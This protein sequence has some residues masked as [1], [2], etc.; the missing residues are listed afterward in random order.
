MSRKKTSDTRH[1]EDHANGCREMLHNY[2]LTMIHLA[3]WLNAMPDVVD[4][5]KAQAVKADFAFGLARYKF[6]L[7]K[8]IWEGADV[9]YDAEARKIVDIAAKHGI[10]RED[11]Q[12]TLMGMIDMVRYWAVRIIP[13]L[14]ENPQYR[15]L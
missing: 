15:G 9:D 1:A 7:N 8:G 5:A 11:Y 4:S 2:D 14:D 6:A 10:D 13:M 12:R 3:G